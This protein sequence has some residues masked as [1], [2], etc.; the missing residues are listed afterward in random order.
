MECSNCGISG[1]IKMLYDVISSEGIVKLCEKCL[2][3]DD[4]AIKKP[5]ASQLN[6]VNTRKSVYDRLSF[7]AGLNPCPGSIAMLFSAGPFGVLHSSR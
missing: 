4:V 6:S 7:S 5:Q 3:K 1:E 2:S